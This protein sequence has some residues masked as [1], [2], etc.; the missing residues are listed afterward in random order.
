MEYPAVTSYSPE[1]PAPCPKNFP[2]ILDLTDCHTP[3]APDLVSPE[4]S[5][6]EP[7]G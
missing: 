2:L 7:P 5:P 3:A 1:A 6:V 4:P